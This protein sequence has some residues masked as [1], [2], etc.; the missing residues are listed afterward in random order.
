VEA[1]IEFDPLK[2]RATFASVS[3]ASLIGCLRKFRLRD[4]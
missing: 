2:N 3:L 4:D 1:K